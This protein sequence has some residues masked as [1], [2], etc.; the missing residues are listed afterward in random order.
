[1]LNYRGLHDIKEDEEDGDDVMEGQTA[2]DSWV[3]I[4]DERSGGCTCVILC[5]VA[6]IIIG[7]IAR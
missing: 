3:M 1:M 7:K 4:L 5:M 2:E 6:M